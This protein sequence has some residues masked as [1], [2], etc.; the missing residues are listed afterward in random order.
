MESRPV[1][2]MVLRVILFLAVLSLALN[3][4]TSV[5]IT[6][7]QPLDLF[8]YEFTV[9]EDGFTIV[10]VTY[11][12]DR[13]SGSSWVLVPRFSEWTYNAVRGEITEWYLRDTQELI[14][15]PHYFYE[16]FCFSFRSDG[17]EFQANVQFNLSIAA[18]II[19]PDGIFYSPQIGFEEGRF[20]ATVALPDGFRV[21]RG[22][23]VAF[24][25]V[26]RVIASGTVGSDS[27]RV[28]FD[29]VP[30]RES[31]MR[32]EVGFRTLN[33]TAE[34]VTFENGIFTFETVLRYEEYAQ[35]ILVLFNETYEDLVSLFNVTLESAEARFFLP[36]FNSLF[37]VGGYVPFVAER[38]GDI[39]INLVFTRYV[40]GYIEVIALHELVHH[41]LWRAGISP[42]DLL[43]FHEG[44]AQY[45]SIE[46]ANELGYEGS[47]MMK[48]EIEDGIPGVKRMTGED[49]GYLKAWS[50]ARSPVDM[51]RYYVAAY[52]VVSQV[53]ES[54]GGL[55]YYARFF[56]LI[57]G[58]EVDSNAAIGYYLS[59]A[60]GESV[61]TELNSW[62]FEI[63]DLYVFS[64]SLRSVEEVLDEVDPIFQP[65]KFLAELLYRQAFLNAREENT[66]EMQL[67][68]AVAVLVAR[69]APLLTLI[70]VSGILFGAILLA[71]REEGVF[72]GR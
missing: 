32:I 7:A 35:E 4:Q 13:A 24:D 67:F 28:L 18:M 61:V 48:Q 39:H 30:E 20:K 38:M 71:L 3:I 6:F 5:G 2:S 29:Y 11:W 34:S 26:G 37:S 50:P 62:G 12:T 44:M 17:S 68:L 49:F 41:F 55:E 63:P 9:D 19:E 53:A 16:A 59:L 33:E 69:L 58:E 21:K 8:S 10:N 14:D 43:W 65:Y 1:S 23:A 31:L 64:P 15:E 25:R 52:Y 27:S 22:E 42:E 47:S 51:G 66:E 56:E 70:T 57:S 36:D 72:S 54:R 40:E 60:A 46:F 45:V